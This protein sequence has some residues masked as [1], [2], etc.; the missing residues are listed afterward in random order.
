MKTL[1]KTKI[2]RV[3]GGEIYF[4]RIQFDNGDLRWERMER[5]TSGIC[6]SQQTKFYA[7]NSVQLS[8]KIYGELSAPLPG[9]F[10]T[11]LIGPYAANDYC[12]G[13]KPEKYF[14][15]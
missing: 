9:D 15:F 14:R 13:H 4:K 1:G 11:D 2:A 3:V 6:N 10:E 8:P 7:Q 12:A 5:D